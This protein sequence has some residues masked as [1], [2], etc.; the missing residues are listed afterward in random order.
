[1][2]SALFIVTFDDVEKGEKAL[3]GIKR[4]RKEHLIEIA[5]AVVIVKDESGKVRVEETDEFTTKRGVIAG[6]S[7][8]LLIGLFVGGPIGGAVLGAAAGALAGKK[9]DLGIPQEKI[10]AVADSM[11][12]ASSAVAFQVQKV[13]NKDMLMAAIRQSGGE[14]HEL[15]ISDDAEVDAAELLQHGGSVR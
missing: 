3:E 11:H 2:A 1:M 9:I 6:G 4:W 13:K 14:L 12:N 15:S 5:D 7:A 8:G 10:D